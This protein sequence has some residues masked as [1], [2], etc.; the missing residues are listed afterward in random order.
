[1]SSIGNDFSA[2]LTGYA[3]Q[4][5]TEVTLS[6]VLVSGLTSIEG[7]TATVFGATRLLIAIPTHFLVDYFLEEHMTGTAGNIARFMLKNFVPFVLATL[8]CVSFGHTFFV[9]EILELGVISLGMAALNPLFRYRNLS[10]QAREISLT[11]TF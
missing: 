3:V 5:L 10:D 6:T 9:A 4:N 8:I 7:T 1:M 11:C 2:S